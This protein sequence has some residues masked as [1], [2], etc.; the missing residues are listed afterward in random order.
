MTDII[1]LQ[2]SQHCKHCKLCFVL[3]LLF[4][5]LQDQRGVTLRLCVRRQAAATPYLFLYFS[6]H[7]CTLG[8]LDGRSLC[9]LFIILNIAAADV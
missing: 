5:P 4:S 1:A 6:N 2:T 3:S 8:W 9:V 7:E